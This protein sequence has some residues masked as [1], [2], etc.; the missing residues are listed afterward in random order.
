M[1]PSE[2]LERDGRL[3][4]TQGIRIRE[5]M[6]AWKPKERCATLPYLTLDSDFSLQVWDKYT[7]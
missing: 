5:Q 6:Y 1:Q 2:A 7:D 3:M 4:Y